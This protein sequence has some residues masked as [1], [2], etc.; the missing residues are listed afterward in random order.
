MRSRLEAVIGDYNIYSPR[1]LQFDTQQKIPFRVSPEPLNLSPDQKKEIEAIGSDIT[2]YYSAV[3]Q[4]YRTDPRVQQL[5]DRGKPEIFCGDKISPSHYLFIRPDLIITASG[6]SICEVETSP[7]GLALAE[8]LNRAYRQEDYETMIDDGTLSVHMQAS[9]PIEG[10]IIDS[11]KTSHFAGQMAFL[12]DE[13]FSGQSRDWQATHADNLN[14]SSPKTI[15]RGFYLAE[16]QTDPSIASLLT[17]PTSDGHDLL[18]SPTPHM[19]EKATLALLWD[20]RFE[21]YFETELGEGGFNHLR[22]VVPP[23]WIV[24]EEEYFVPGMPNGISSSVD[25]ARFSRSKRAF[26]L[27]PSGFRT[28]ASWGEGVKFLQKKSAVAA[29]LAVKEALDDR[30]SLHIVQQF[31]KA[32]EMP[33]AYEDN[34]NDPTPMSARVRLTPYF[35]MVPGKEGQLIAIKAT[36]CEDT[37]LVHASSVSINTAVN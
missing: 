29:A 8:I 20:K 32:A 15:Y 10:I 2:S 31:T 24:G 19:E 12:A 16:L 21:S 33:M 35:S 14:G 17:G 27:K 1:R 3:D 34:G 13:V 36:G 5:L 22:H 26:V 4:L 6:F 25:L 7:F 30:S 37:D 28:D 23:S 9:T 18:P 11:Q